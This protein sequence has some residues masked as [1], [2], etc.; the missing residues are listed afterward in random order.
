MGVET[1]APVTQ[2]K[3]GVSVGFRVREEAVGELELSSLDFH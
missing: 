3:A 1:A 2:E